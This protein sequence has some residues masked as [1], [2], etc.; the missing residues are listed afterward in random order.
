MTPCDGGA[1]LIDTIYFEE[2]VAGHPRTRALRARFQKAAQIP[3]TRYGEVFNRTAQNFRL[4]KHKPALILAEKQD[5]QVLEAPQSYGIGGRRNYYFSHLLNCLYDCRYCFLAGM[6]RSAH[7]LLFV[8]YEDFERAIDA[9][10][11]LFPGEDVTFFSGY[12]GDSL[13]L[14]PLSGFVE[15]FLPF[16]RARSRALLEL[17]TKS[18]RIKPL[19][20][21]APFDNCV[22]AFSFTP[23]EL[24]EVVEHQVPSVATRLQAMRE[25][26]RHGW[27]LGLRFDPLLY[28]K[29]F[30]NRYRALFRSAFEIVPL[31]AIHSVSLGAFRLPRDFFG[32]MTR[33]Y[34]DESLFAGP[35]EQRG[36][37][38]SYHPEIE[39]EMRSFCE[40]ELAQY[41]PPDRLHLCELSPP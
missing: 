36:R 5:N 24:S 41:L 20:A 16:F 35:L 21:A 32:R 26:A 3:I 14:E 22:V 31:E 34:P 28:G 13:A 18:P 7:Y 2:G 39:A 11:S 12:D 4:Q 30:R 9:R 1:S 19:L 15:S 29:D 25:L 38:V 17:R 33:L 23:R 10:L 27:R 37:M 40:E 6:Y 8:N